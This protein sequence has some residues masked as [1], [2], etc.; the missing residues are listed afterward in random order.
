MINYI[1]QVVLIR[2]SL[3]QDARNKERI[4]HERGNFRGVI[5]VF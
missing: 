1:L 4:F 5:S 3:K 2:G